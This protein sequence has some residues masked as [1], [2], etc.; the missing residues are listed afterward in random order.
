MDNPDIGHKIQDEDKQN[1][2]HNI[3]NQTMNN[4]DLKS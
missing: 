2:T 3:E 4:T 1:K